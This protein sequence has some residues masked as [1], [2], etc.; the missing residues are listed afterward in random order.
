MG[1]AERWLHVMKT[2]VTWP[3]LEPLPIMTQAF[4]VSLE[5]SYR[6]LFY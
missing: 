3:H 5:I 1:A 6:L 4:P 2:Q